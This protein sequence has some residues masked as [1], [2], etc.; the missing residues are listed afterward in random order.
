[1]RNDLLLKELYKISRFSKCL[2]FCKCFN[3]FSHKCFW[4]ETESPPGLPKPNWTIS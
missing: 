2:Y 4:L 3:S 1:L